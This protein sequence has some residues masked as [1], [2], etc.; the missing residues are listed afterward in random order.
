MSRLKPFVTA[1]AFEPQ[2]LSFRTSGR[3]CFL[4]LRPRSLSSSGTLLL[5]PHLIILNNTHEYW[6]T[7]AVRGV[8]WL[9]QY[10]FNHYSLSPHPH[11]W[12]TPSCG[13]PTT[14]ITTFFKRQQRNQF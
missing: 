7:V 14:N 6:R 9:S 13:T 10:V 5:L 8:P 2:G 12:N 11:M 3:F 4:Y 1:Q